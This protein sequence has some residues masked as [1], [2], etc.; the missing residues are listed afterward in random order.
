MIEGCVDSHNANQKYF[1]LEA[2]EKFRI[3]SGA[4]QMA[5]V[6]SKYLDEDFS[7][8]GAEGPS[9][10]AGTAFSHLIKIL[11]AARLCRPDL[12]VAITRLASKA[13]VGRSAMIGR[14]AD[15]PSTLRIML[16]S[17][18]STFSDMP[19][20]KR[21]YRDKKAPFHRSAARKKSALLVPVIN[22]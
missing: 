8:K 21:V 15:S 2:A 14:C 11:F 16:T 10:F 22:R 12:F 19:C 4:E 20:M 18:W 7:A 9:V 17:S 1:V 6:E 5:S 3:E 13:S